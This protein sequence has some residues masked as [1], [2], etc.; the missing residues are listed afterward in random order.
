[1]K[2][3]QLTIL[4]LL[5]MAIL[6]GLNA[7]AQDAPKPV[8]VQITKAHWDM[9]YDGK[10]SDLLKLETEYHQKVTMKNK[11]ILGTNVLR[12]EFTPDVSEVLFIQVYEK[13][14]DIDKAADEDYRLS[15]LSWP[16][17]TVRRANSIARNKFYTS[18]HSDEILTSLPYA[19]QNP[20]PADSNLTILYKVNHLAF[21]EDGSNKEF[22]ELYQEYFDHVL[23][24]NTDLLGYYPLRHHTGADGRDFVEIMV[25]KSL[26]NLDNG[27]NM[28]AKLAKEHWPDLEKRNAFFDK[29]SK[30]FENWHGDA[31]Y[32]NMHQLHK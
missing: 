4:S 9:D 28:N 15:K 22:R 29:L 3:K 13:F 27:L 10:A 30:Y 5:T 23:N 17:S 8:I 18:V 19:K 6:S 14:E 1:M 16:D 20:N 31:I 7:L 2:I 12:H 26:T 32:A 24:K 21:P 11:Y 25:F